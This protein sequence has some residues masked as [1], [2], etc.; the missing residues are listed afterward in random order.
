MD[1]KN[2]TKGKRIASYTVQKI[3][4]VDLLT[5]IQRYVNLKKVGTQYKGLSPFNE[6]RS[7]SFFVVPSKKLWK[8]FSSQ[9]GGVGAISFLMEYKHLSFPQAIIE[10]AQNNGIEVE[11]E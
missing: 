3:K 6:E 5:E 9:K 11:Y 4:E 7:P 2:H 10:I 8:C 1:N